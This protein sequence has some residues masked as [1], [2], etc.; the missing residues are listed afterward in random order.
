MAAAGGSF[1]TTPRV[2]TVAVSVLLVGLALLSMHMRLPSA[3]NFVAPHRL[4]M[5]VGG[6][7][8]LLAGVL[9]RRL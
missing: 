4:W 1:V 2:A 5:I 6:Y 8:V 7:G 3:L 9:L